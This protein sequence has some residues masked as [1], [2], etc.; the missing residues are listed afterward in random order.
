ML[1]QQSQRATLSLSQFILVNSTETPAMIA[2]NTTAYLQPLFAT[3][4][5][6]TSSALVR[7]F[8]VLQNTGELNNS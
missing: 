7:F 1:H 6:P 5:V 4:H 8:V 3:E 2:F